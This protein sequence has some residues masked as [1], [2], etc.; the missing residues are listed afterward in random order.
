MVSKVIDD[1]GNGFP[2]YKVTWAN[3]Q[4]SLQA[5]YSHSDIQNY[6]DALDIYMGK[7]R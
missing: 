1:Y 5:L 4:E 7:V 2:M 6:K 3:Y